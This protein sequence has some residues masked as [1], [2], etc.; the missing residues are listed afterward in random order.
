MISISEMQTRN[1]ASATI[2][3]EL[4]LMGFTSMYCFFSEKNDYKNRA[5]S[6]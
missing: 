3:V 4:F 6:V 2:F 5:L 1:A